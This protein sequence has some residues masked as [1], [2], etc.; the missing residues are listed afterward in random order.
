[1]KLFTII[2]LSLLSLS[3]QA[4][5][6]IEVKNATIRVL[7]P[8]APVTS[9]AMDIRNNLDKDIKLVSV[10][11]DFAKTFELHTMDMANGMMK[12]RKVDFIEIKKKSM[13]QLKSGGH[14]IMV[15]GLKAPVKDTQ[16]YSIA[17]KFEKHAE[18]TVEAIG[19][20][21]MDNHHH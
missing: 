20:N 5:T 18:I 11:G 13:A 9:M 10:S 1:M 19:K 8:G 14:H 2:A 17:L 21:E 16:K 15:F 7:P 6:D 12:M 4:L 3:T